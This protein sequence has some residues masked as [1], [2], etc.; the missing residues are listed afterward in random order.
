MRTSLRFEKG[1]IS[2][3]LAILLAALLWSAPQRVQAQGL[4]LADAV[5]SALAQNPD[6]LVQRAQIEAAEGQQQQAAGQFDWTVSSR[7]HFDRDISPLTNSFRDASAVATVAQSKVVST[8]YQFGIG[9]QLRNGLVVGASVDAAG[10]EDNQAVPL[11]G[12]QNL[13]RLGVTLRIPLLQGRG[14]SVTAPED[15]AGL[16]AQ[17]RGYELLDRAA[18]KM[19][20]TIV[21]YWN[22]RAQVD[23]ERI[24]A[25]SE[26]RSRKLLESIQKL[27]AA[28][29][30]PA[31][32]LVL[33]NADHA[34]KMVAHEAAVLA[35]TQSRQALGRLLGMDARAIAAMPE[36]ADQLPGRAAAPEGGRPDADALRRDALARRPDLRAL[37]LQKEAAQRD[38]EGA[39][40]QLK[41]R[42]DLD[43]GVAYAKASEGGPR[44]GMLT[45]PGRLQSTPSVSVRLSYEFPVAGN[46]A[47]GEVRERSALL[48]QIQIQQRDLASGV[49]TEVDSAIQA[50]LSSSTQLQVGR[51]GLA[52]YEQAVNQEIT[53][54]RNGISTLIDVINTESRYVSARV[55]FLQSQLAYATALA[56]LRLASGALFPAPDAAGELMLDLTRLQAPDGGP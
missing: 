20:Q 25:N 28:S 40:D 26:E 55:N 41:P 11:Q 53:K 48:S 16:V 8:G 34:D 27:V 49:E 39:R 32:D 47:K 21:A 35:R 4:R 33:A 24:A 56:Q 7:L 2:A 37:E 36:P 3:C 42:L 15:A 43:V 19:Y 30:K 12:Q 13:T 54:Q 31:A 51:T 45:A 10:T 1:T 6:I 50:L 52:L 17:A 9:K 44:Y 14:N 46:R 5:R 23:L 29:E 18:R 22:F 38:F